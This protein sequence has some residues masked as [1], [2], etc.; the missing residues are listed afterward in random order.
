MTCVLE[1]RPVP[2]WPRPRCCLSGSRPPCHSRGGGNPESCFAPPGAMP[3][4]AVGMSLA[5]RAVWRDALR[6]VRLVIPDLQFA[7]GVIPSVVPAGRDAVEESQNEGLVRSAFRQV[8]PVPI[9]NVHGC[10][11]TPQSPRACHSCAKLALD[12]IGSHESNVVGAD[13]IRPRIDAIRQPPYWSSL[14]A[15]HVSTAVFVCFGPYSAKR[16]GGW[17]PCAERPADSPSGVVATDAAQRGESAAQTPSDL[18][19]CLHYSLSLT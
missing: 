8:V 3:T 11:T 9:L 6:R 15:C 19:L 12:P 5:P 16:S 1:T 10:H 17:R 2:S 14:K 13:G 7:V 4:F 18:A